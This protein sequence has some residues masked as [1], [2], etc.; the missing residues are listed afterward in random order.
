MREKSGDTKH[1]KHA[2]ETSKR[3][4]LFTVTP[5]TG[6]MAYNKGNSLRKKEP[7]QERLGQMAEIRRKVAHLNDARERGCPKL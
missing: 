7:K 5:Q 2:Q 4:H 1:D 3:T 6:E